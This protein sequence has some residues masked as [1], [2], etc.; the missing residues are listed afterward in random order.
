M[1]EKILG[2]KKEE[3]AEFQ[4]TELDYSERKRYSF[5]YALTHPNHSIG[6]IAEVKKASPSKGIFR[7]TIDPAA[8]GKEYALAGADCISVLTD[9]TYFQGSIENLVKVREQVKIPILR[10]DFIIDHRQVEES[11]RIGADAILLIAAALE[12]KK[13]LDLYLYAEELGLE[14]LVE[15]HNE[16]E[17]DQVLTTFKP[18][19][20]GINNRNLKT[21]ETTLE[22]TRKL[23]S[24]V[25][26]DLVLVSE[27]GVHTHEN[28]EFLKDLGVNGCLVGEALIRAK[29]PTDGIN[30]LFGLV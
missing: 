12:P 28:I 9:Q 17:L 13:L 7:E 16:K 19:V 27:S 18:S 4:M 21:F 14:S 20:L 25:P 26:K 24:M 10:K 23:V 11:N 30:Q 3:L 8:I 29:T 1:L 15:V 2:T 22:T 5:K 6:L